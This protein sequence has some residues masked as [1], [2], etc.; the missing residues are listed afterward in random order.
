VAHGRVVFRSWRGLASGGA[1]EEQHARVAGR[2]GEFYRM[3]VDILGRP[4]ELVQT[5]HR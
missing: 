1:K 5:W 2:A 3:E 4:I